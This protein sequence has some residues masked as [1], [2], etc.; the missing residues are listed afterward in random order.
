M[1]SKNKPI[2][3]LDSGLGGLSILKEIVEILP[4]ESIIYFADSKNCPY[5]E[6]SLTEIKKITT[7]VIEFLIKKD[8][9]LILIACNSI[10][11]V[12]IDE[13]RGLYEVPFVG[14]EPATLVAAKETRKGKIGVLATKTTAQSNLFKQTKNKVSPR[15]DVEI[16]IGKGLVELVEEGRIKN[17]EAR[18]VVLSNLKNF[19]RKGVDQVVL[20][21]THYPF[22]KDVMKEIAPEMNFIDPSLA[23]AR[24]VG[25]ILTKENLLS[26]YKKPFWKLYFSKKAK[27]MELLL[28]TTGLKEIKVRERVIF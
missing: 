10:T 9:K 8:C 16:E 14:V 4:N 20:G 18:G 11:S 22:L 15:I 12:F 3:I 24:Q 5:G 17:K 27:G 1:H 23:V 6:K 26:T 28:K 19:K 21:C 2:G 7:K 13:L 25:I